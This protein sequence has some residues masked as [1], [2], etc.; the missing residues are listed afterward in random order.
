MQL[1]TV[2]IAAAGI[3]QQDHQGL[4]PPD[5]R[6]RRGKHN[7]RTGI[8]FLPFEPRR[9]SITRGFYGINVHRYSTHVPLH[10]VYAWAGHLS[11]P[12][13]SH[14]A[15]SVDPLG[16]LVAAGESVVRDPLLLGASGPPRQRIP[17]GAIRYRA[18]TGSGSEEPQNHESTVRC[19]TYS[20]M[21]NALESW[22]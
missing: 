16:W 3:L 11:S 5:T 19:C 20:M 1:P 22:L 9:T 4:H 7:R 2:R 13:S 14:G 8:R 15:F 18:N 6:K 12:A 17:L 10:R 21:P